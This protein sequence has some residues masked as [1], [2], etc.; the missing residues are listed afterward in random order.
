MPASIACLI[1]TNPGS[2]IPGVPASE[3]NAMCFHPLRRSII[4]STLENPECE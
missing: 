1:S 4:F 2:D 3:T